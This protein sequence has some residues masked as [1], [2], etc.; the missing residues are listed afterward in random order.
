VAFDSQLPN[1][2]NTG[3][4][5]GAE[6]ES[7]YFGDPI[8]EH[9]AVLR[10]LKILAVGARCK[11]VAYATFPDFAPG[12]L[13]IFP[14]SRAPA[15][16]ICPAR[17]AIQPTAGDQFWIGDDFFHGKFMLNMFTPVKWPVG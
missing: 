1:L 12:G 8:I 6:N 14:A 2:T 15:A 10:I 7:E 9:P 16:E 3:R 11:L 17:P 4:A 13:V 5:I